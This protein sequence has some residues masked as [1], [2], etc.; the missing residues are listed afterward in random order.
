MGGLKMTE[1]NEP[2]RFLRDHQYK[3][4]VVFHSPVPLPGRAY[5]D[6]WGP[7]M[8]MACGPYLRVDITQE[9]FAVNLVGL[10]EQP[11]ETSEL[12]LAPVVLATRNMCSDGWAY[13]QSDVE[14]SE[15]VEWKGMRVLSPA[16]GVK[17]EQLAESVR[18]ELFPDQRQEA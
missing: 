10:Q 5:P 12:V 17:P 3:L 6:D 8:V 9:G 15:W 16:D 14:G 13:H 2:Q 1:L 11:S 18:S 7:E 4:F